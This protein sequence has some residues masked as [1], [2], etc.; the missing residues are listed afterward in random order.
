[1]SLAKVTSLSFSQYTPS[2]GLNH[3]IVSGKCVVDRVGRTRITSDFQHLEE[4][5]LLSNVVHLAKMLVRVPLFP[6]FLN[7]NQTSIIQHHIMNQ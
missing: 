4:L 5:A 3:E 1:M 2:V 7:D 6:L